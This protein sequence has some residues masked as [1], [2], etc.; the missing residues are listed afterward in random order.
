MVTL[1]NVTQLTLWKYEIDELT[2]WRALIDDCPSEYP[3]IEVIEK[4][5]AN[6][7]SVF[8]SVKLVQN[9]HNYKDSSIKWRKYSGHNLNIPN[10]ILSTDYKIKEA[11]NKMRAKDW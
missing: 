9:I 7:K 1:H 10:Q 11:S 3:D 2:D 5:M 6:H 4:Y 8:I